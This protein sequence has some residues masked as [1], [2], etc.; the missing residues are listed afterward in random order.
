MHH[1][2]DADRVTENG[3]V[4]LIPSAQWAPLVDAT[5]RVTNS[6]VCWYD[7]PPRVLLLSLTFIDFHNA[8]QVEVN[9][10]CSTSTECFIADCWKAPLLTLLC[11]IVSYQ[12]CVFSHRFLMPNPL[13]FNWFYNA[14]QQKVVPGEGRQ[15]IYR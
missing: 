4:L 10:L 15:P 2:G 7:C 13:E 9:L 3:S 5:G 11:V 14:I 1:D 12:V 8:S 6:D